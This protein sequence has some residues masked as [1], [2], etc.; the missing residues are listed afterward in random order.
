[1]SEAVKEVPLTPSL[2]ELNQQLQQVQ[3]QRVSLKDQLE[4][5]DKALPLIVTQIQTIQ[6]MNQDRANGF[7]VDKD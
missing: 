5:L 6:R 2:E 3:L 7:G 1:M 4:Q